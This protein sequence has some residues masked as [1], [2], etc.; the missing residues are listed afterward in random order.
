[1]MQCTHLDIAYEKS[2]RIARPY[3]FS[4]HTFRCAVCDVE[5][6]VVDREKIPAQARRRAPES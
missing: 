3:R 1:M 2:E 6:A 4:L 5:A